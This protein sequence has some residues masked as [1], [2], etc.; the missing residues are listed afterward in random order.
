[1]LT[2][3]IR[4]AVAALFWVLVAAFTLAELGTL[5]PAAGERNLAAVTSSSRR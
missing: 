3:W 1:M 2:F 5:P 4:P